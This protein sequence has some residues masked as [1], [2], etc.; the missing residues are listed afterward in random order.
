MAGVVLLWLLVECTLFVVSGATLLLS[1]GVMGGGS[2]AVAAVAV[3]FGGAASTGCVGGPEE[4]KIVV[5]LI[6]GFCDNRQVHLASEYDSR[7]KTN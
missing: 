2:D 5:K 7:L 1:P 3:V 6:I 4:E